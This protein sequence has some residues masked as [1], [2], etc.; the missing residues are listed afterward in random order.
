MAY[1]VLLNHSACLLCPGA[2]PT[3][4]PS[5]LGEYVAEA[6]TCLMMSGWSGSGLCRACGL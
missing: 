5:G 4:C 1:L 2:V 3:F 6:R